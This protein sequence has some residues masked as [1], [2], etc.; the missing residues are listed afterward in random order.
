MFITFEGVDGS[1]KTTAS[2]ALRNYLASMGYNV[3]ITHDPGGTL[4]GGEIRAILKS[5]YWH[6]GSVTKLLLVLASHAE[7]VR[8]VIQ[9]GLT[10]GIVICDGF[11]DSTY[12]YQEADQGLPVELVMKLKQCIMANCI[13]DITFLLD[14]DPAVARERTTIQNSRYE[15]DDAELLFMKRVRRAYLNK[16]A[17]ESWRFV[18]VDAGQSLDDVVDIVKEYTYR[19]LTEQVMDSIQSESVYQPIPYGKRRR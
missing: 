16:A 3:E 15:Y 4:A 8:T 11:V 10:R 6:L 17:S 5:S 7:L 1:G 19:A 14:V 12:A 9:P 18:I 13:P 2:R